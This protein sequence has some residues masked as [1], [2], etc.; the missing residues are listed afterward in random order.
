MIM[1]DHDAPE[2]GGSGEEELSR[3]GSQAVQLAAAIGGPVTVAT[4]LL[5]YFGWVRTTVEAQ[6]LGVSD[7]VFGYSTQDYV[8][9]SINALFLPV[10][11]AAVVGIVALLLHSW[12]ARGMDKGP[13]SR[14]HRAARVLGALLL[15][16]CLV[17][18]VLGALA[19]AHRPELT[20]LIL[21]LAD[22]DD[23]G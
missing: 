10:V 1:I 20:G 5:F 6:T 2:L 21:P 23:P 15:F 16:A 17:T 14:R 9:R 12:L 7:A 4:A 13:T 8:L 3:T 22:R 11:V 19:E 18:P